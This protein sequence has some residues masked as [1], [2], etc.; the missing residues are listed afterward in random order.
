MRM[1]FAAA[2]AAALAVPT[3]SVA[4]DPAYKPPPKPM[5]FVP[6]PN[7]G[8]HVYGSPI[9]QPVVGHA[10][11]H[12]QKQPP[13]KQSRANTSHTPVKHRAKQGS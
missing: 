5:S 6:H 10:K 3:L 13:K 2:L 4:G 7:S 1:F 12:H 9:G 8:Q 11:A